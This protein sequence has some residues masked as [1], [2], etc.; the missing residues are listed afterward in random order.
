MNQVFNLV[1][2]YLRITDVMNMTLVNRELAILLR[3]RVSQ[4]HKR[5]CA[6]Q[7]RFRGE[8]RLYSVTVDDQCDHIIFVQLNRQWWGMEAPHKNRRTNYETISFYDYS[9]S[10]HFNYDGTTTIGQIFN[11]S[12]TRR[13]IE[14]HGSQEIIDI[15]HGRDARVFS[16]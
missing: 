12:E 1:S 6:I 5:V 10:M 13:M 14:E 2:G 16:K 4:G 11:A 15:L 7:R 3:W 8:D 9:P